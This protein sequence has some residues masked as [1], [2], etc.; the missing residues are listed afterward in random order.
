[1]DIKYCFYQPGGNKNDDNGSPEKKDPSRGMTLVML[2]VA[3]SID[4]AAIGLSLAALKEPVMF[5]AVIIG[6]V[7]IFCSAFGLF[8][9]SRIGIKIGKWAERFGGLVLILLGL[10]ICLEHLL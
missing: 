4:A 7:C 5:P 8:L 1:M 9:G 6:I 3:T 10:K 2:S